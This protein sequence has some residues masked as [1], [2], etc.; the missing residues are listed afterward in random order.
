MKRYL[1][2]V[3]FLLVVLV[4]GFSSDMQA[5]PIHGLPAVHELWVVV[6]DQLIQRGENTCD[7]LLGDAPATQRMEVWVRAPGDADFSLYH[8]A[9]YPTGQSTPITI[10]NPGVVLEAKVR[11]G[12]GIYDRPSCWSEVRQLKPWEGRDPGP[13]DEKWADDRWGD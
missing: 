11:S 3:V 2:L 13:G 7:L 1:V 6:G 10:Y 12:A 9:Q 8:A 5:K 4:A